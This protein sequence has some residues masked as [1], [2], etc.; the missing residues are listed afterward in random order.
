M[1]TESW[2]EVWER[3]VDGLAGRESDARVFTLPN[4]IAFDGFD[5]AMGKAGIHTWQHIIDTIKN[6]LDIQCGESLVE[7]GCGAG[8]ILFGLA[9]TGAQLSGTDYSAEHIEIA[10]KALPAGHF[11]VAEA[12][13]QPFA[14]NSFDKVLSHGVF[15]YFPD[16]EYAKKTIAEMLRI[17]RSPQKILIMDIPDAAKKTTTEA[18]RRAA[19]ASLTPP[20]LYYPKSFFE[21]AAARH[22]LHVRVFDQVI[23]GYGN[24]AFRFNVLLEAKT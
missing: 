16:L 20:H 2:K 3:K 9:D 17:C 4:L 10:R 11:Q 8:A 22:G 19:G 15:L 6:H 24:A 14:D 21:Q 12:S 23:P 7:V 5:G 1:K 13:A 18:A